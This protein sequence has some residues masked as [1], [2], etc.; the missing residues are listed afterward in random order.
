MFLIISHIEKK[1][2]DIFR[3]FRYL[4]LISPYLYL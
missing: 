1:Q 2:I 4:P 3:N